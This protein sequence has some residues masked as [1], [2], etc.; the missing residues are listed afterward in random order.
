MGT[1]S[2]KD[3][4]KEGGELV[5]ST[6]FH[7]VELHLPTAGY[8]TL[9]VILMVLSAWILVKM[10]SRLA[11]SFSRRRN[12][13]PYTVTPRNFGNVGFPT[14]PYA[15]PLPMLPIPPLTLPAIASAPPY[16]FEHQPSAR[17]SGRRNFSPFPEEASRLE[18][19][20]LTVPSVGPSPPS[21]RRRLSTGPSSSKKTKPSTETF[22]G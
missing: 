9:T 6:G 21:V 3:S 17:P 20:E 16:N 22:M 10:R 7:L 12:V 13:L 8:G 15:A 4:P 14:N 11:K 19:V 1:S 5:K 18:C 2:S